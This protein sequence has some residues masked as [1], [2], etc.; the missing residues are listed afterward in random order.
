[1]I[2]A[3]VTGVL[4]AGLGVFTASA[5]AGEMVVTGRDAT[6][7]AH[8]VYSPVKR[9]VWVSSRLAARPASIV[10]KP[11]NLD[12]HHDD[13]IE[14]RVVNTS[15][16]IDPNADQMH[17]GEN[18]IDENHHIPAAQRLY[19]SL[20]AKPARIITRNDH[21]RQAPQPRTRPSMILMRPSSMPEMHMDTPRLR[22]P[23]KLKKKTIPSVPSP[24]KKRQRLI[25][26]TTTPPVM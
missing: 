11:M 12:T 7:R 2:K 8:R 14:V 22:V 1:M 10:S 24:P 17:Q 13:L 18:R 16:Y 19:R 6:V 3:M 15:I 4:L 25:A 23:R 20:N 5:Q 26:M 9:R 21:R